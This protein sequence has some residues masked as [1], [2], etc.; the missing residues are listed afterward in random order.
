[1]LKRTYDIHALACPK[2]GGRLKFIAVIAVITDAPVTR[3]I[4]KS[5]G[6]R[7]DRP[8]IARARAPTDSDGIDPRAGDE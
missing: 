4:L 7:A 2:C 8:V 3:T 6:E 1:L 5:M